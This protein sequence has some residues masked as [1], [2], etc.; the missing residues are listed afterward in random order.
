M[1][2]N[3]ETALE[4]ADDHSPER[5][6]MGVELHREYWGW[7]NNED[8]TQCI[9]LC[10]N[11]GQRKPVRCPCCY[12]KAGFRPMHE[13]PEE[14]DPVP[15][16]GERL[17]AWLGACLAAFCEA[18][19]TPFRVSRQHHVAL[20]RDV[21]QDAMDAGLT[22]EVVQTCPTCDAHDAAQLAQ[23]DTTM[24]VEVVENS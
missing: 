7:T 10:L 19:T 5:S 22:A 4:I 9:V 17:A 15:T 24:T 2:E 14:I 6:Q 8:H 16:R 12:G 18:V 11:P 21:L 20:I 3:S 13:W 23:A 1:T